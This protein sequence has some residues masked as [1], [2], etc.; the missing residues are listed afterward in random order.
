MRMI[1]AERMIGGGSSEAAQKTFETL[2]IK[3]GGPPEMLM[4]SADDRLILAL[5]NAELVAEF[6]GFSMVSEADLPKNGLLVVGDQTV[7]DTHFNR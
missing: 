1:W 5:P 2:F 3:L 6:D 7:F 4:V